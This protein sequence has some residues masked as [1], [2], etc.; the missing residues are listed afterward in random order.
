MHMEHCHTDACNEQQNHQHAIAGRQTN[1]THGDG[2]HGR[3]QDNEPAHADAVGQGT[4]IRIEQ[5]RHLHDRRKESCL[6]QGHGKLFDQ[7]GQER[8]QKAG[9]HVVNEVADGQG[10]DLPCLE[11]AVPVGFRLV[12]YHPGIIHNIL[13][14]STHYS[15]DCKQIQLFLGGANMGKTRLCPAPFSA[16]AISLKTGRR[17]PLLPGGPVL[18]EE[19]KLLATRFIYLHRKVVIS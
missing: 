18:L 16:R 4:D 8:R 11:N 1:Q 3:G 6:G 14:R 15:V 19:D 7:Q 12:V 9:I 10:D 13:P 2:G 5:G 17:C